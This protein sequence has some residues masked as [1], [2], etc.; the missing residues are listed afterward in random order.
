MIG[1]DIFIFDRIRLLQ[2]AN[3][4]SLS[5]HFWLM[6]G[7]EVLLKMVEVGTPRKTLATTTHTRRLSGRRLSSGSLSG[8]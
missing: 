8:E 1:R 4:F 5:C 3:L 2:L 6:S 7:I